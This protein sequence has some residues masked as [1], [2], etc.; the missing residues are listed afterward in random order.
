MILSVE[1]QLS[2]PFSAEMH[3]P[4][5]PTAEGREMAL[6]WHRPPPLSLKPQTPDCFEHCPKTN[7]GEMIN[8]ENAEPVS[9]GQRNRPRDKKRSLDAAVSKYRMLCGCFRLQ[10]FHTT[11]IAGAA[12]AHTHTRTGR[13]TILD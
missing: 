1:A 9:T 6:L 13:T 5:T 2:P 3:F 4:P 8:A 12:H 7:E 10:L 11:E